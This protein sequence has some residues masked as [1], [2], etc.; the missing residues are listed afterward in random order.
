MPRIA[1]V[2]GRYIAH[3]AAAV[4]IEDRGYQ[5]SDGVYEVCEVA[6]GHIIDMRRHLDR[7]NRSLSELSIDWPLT[8]SALEIVIREVVRRNGVVNGLVYL[9][10]TR[11]VAPRDHGFPKPGTRSSLVVT[12]KKIDP[13]I[14]VKKAETG[15]KVITVP[16]NRWERVDIKSVGLLPNVL[17]KQKAREAGAQEAWFIDADGLV[18]EGAST[19]AWIVTR[20]GVLVTRPADRGILRGITRTTLFEVA[21]KLGLRIEERAFSVAEAKA[22]REVFVSSATTIAM[23]VV[24]I[25]GETVAN[26]HP[27]SITLSLREAFFDVAEKSPA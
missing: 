5:F 7:L 11:G 15:F 21:E 16:E 10:V 19:N 18:T 4:H 13:S 12:A 2:N 1:Y 3:S 27:G 6:R 24:A 26:G 20:E 9:Q 25:D 14:A 17:A 23:P 22:A 8:R